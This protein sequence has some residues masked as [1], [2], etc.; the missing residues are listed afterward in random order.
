VFDSR[1][2]RI[3]SDFILPLPRMILDSIHLLERIVAM[4][5]IFLGLLQ[6]ESGVASLE[7]G[8]ICS[9]LGLVIVSS[10]RGVSIG[11]N[12]TFNTISLALQTR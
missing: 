10:L 2:S 12:S 5:R 9:V 7:Y 3:L 6:D 8:L 1:L 4:S 11:L